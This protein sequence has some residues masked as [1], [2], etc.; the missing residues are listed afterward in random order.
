MPWLPETFRKQWQ[1]LLKEARIPYQRPHDLRHTYAS[2]LIQHGVNLVYLKDQLGHS[3][4]KI[5]VD[6]Y[7]HL[8]PG[9]DRA[10]VNRLDNL[11][12]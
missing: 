3:S 9:T 7:G 2:L 1:K 11:T 5:T 12:G 8:T 6:T 4:I 10:A